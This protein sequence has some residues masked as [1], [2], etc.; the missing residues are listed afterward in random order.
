MSVYRS[1]Q[2]KQVDMAA[3]AA[4]NEKVR[5]VGNMS[6]NARGDTIDSH[7][8]VIKSVTEKVSNGYAQTVGNRSANATKQPQRPLV[9][10]KVKPVQ[11]KPV[12]ELMLTPEELELEESIDDIEIEKI[13]AKETG[14][15]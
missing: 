2:G 12:E 14:K 10:D 7:G 6:V 15:K 13:K 8:R 11:P 4:K 9:P 3:L 1:A 5:A